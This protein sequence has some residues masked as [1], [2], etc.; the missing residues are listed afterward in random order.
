MRLALLA[1]I[2]VI[3]IAQSWAVPLAANDDDRQIGL[4][5]LADEGAAH[6]NEGD[7]EARHWGGGW[8]GGGWGGG[9]WGGWGGR[10]WGGGWGGGGWGGGWGGGGWGGGW[11]RH[12]G[13]GGGWGGW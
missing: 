2:G 11:H 12:G 13:W 10:R 1:L 9:G 3:C 8:G 6:A 7:R 4:L 5:D